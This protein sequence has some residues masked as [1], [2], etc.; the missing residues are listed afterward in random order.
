MSAPG[1]SW[2]SHPKGI[3]AIL[4]TSVLVRPHFGAAPTRVRQWLDAFVRA[5]RQVIPEVIPSAG[6][7]VVGGD[8]DDIPVLHTAYATAA[9]GEELFDVL[10]ASR[11]D[12]GCFLVSENTRHF[13]PGWNVYGWQFI[14]AHA[15]LERLHKRGTRDT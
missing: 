4:E 3:V 1:A 15:F 8:V 7:E 14:T 13:T 9:A 6:A 5:S 10:Q 11:I 12:G 2:F